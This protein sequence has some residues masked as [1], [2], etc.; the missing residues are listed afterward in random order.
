MSEAPK[1][2][3]L[4]RFSLRMLFL[5]TAVVALIAALLRL[6]WQRTQIRRQ[7]LDSAG[8]VSGHQGILQG[9]RSQI[10]RSTV[11]GILF[12]NHDVTHIWLR[13]GACDDDDLELIRD[14]FPE[15]A[16]ADEEQD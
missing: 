10:N 1:P 15:A 12:D 6:S 8:A 9:Y 3:R 13:P 14:L 4:F 5:A 7:Y 11:S 2:K 16:I